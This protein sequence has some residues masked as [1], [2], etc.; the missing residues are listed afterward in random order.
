MSVSRP[1][2]CLFCTFSRAASTG[3][4]VPRRQFH[5]SPAQLKEKPKQPM[6]KESDMK[7]LQEIQKDL[8]PS[9]FKPYTEEEKARLSEVY[10]PE[11]IAAIEA[12]EAAIDPKDL[13][14]QFAIR[15]DPMKFH[16]LD[17]FSTIEPVVDKHIRAPESNSDYNAR[18]KDED[19]FAEDFA[20]FFAEMP[21]NATAADWVRFTENLRLT[22]GKEENERNP[23]SALVP[24]LFQPGE[25]LSRDLP[26]EGAPK[27]K[28]KQDKG[29]QSEE[30]TDALKRLLQSTGYTLDMIRSLKLKTLVSHPVVNQ[31]RLG[32]VRRQ[33]CL[34][35]AGNGNGLLGIG[36]A[37]SEEAGDAMTQSKYRA[38]RNMQPI[39]RY[40]NRTIYGDVEGKVGAVELKL[41]T[42]PPGF[43]LRCQHLI[44]EMA[45][46]AGIHDLAARVTRSRNPM[47][48]V[49]AAYEALM[50]Q[51]DPEDIARAR[52]RKLVDVRK[53]YYAGR[54]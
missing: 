37:K 18:L 11:Q 29:Q 17:D 3:A 41:M 50:S 15:R 28:E 31:T 10:S 33:Y 48:T 36:E 4:R 13:A 39:L 47:N 54:V 30:M 1:A 42:R 21:E 44:F 16:Y 24:D 5:A 27:E 38:I 45:R 26:P 8:K 19:D 22:I 20:R 46:A 51:K 49:K 9:D 7:T 53:V 12:G 14:E 52:G 40:E 35:I 34:S 32:K 2:R 6:I 25:S 23:S 43:G